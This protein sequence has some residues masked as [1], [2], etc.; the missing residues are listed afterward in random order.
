MRSRCIAGPLRT[1]VCRRD[2]SRAAFPTIQISFS[3]R[4]PHPRPSHGIKSWYQVMASSHGIKSWHR[5]CR[6]VSIL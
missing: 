2:R 4:R 1:I 3:S 5:A 6:R